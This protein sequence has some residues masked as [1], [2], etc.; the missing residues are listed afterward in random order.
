ME[1]LTQQEAA[2]ILRLSE[3]TLE[4]HRLSG[5]GPPF[6]KLGR[7]VVYRRADIEAWTRANNRLS[8]CETE[9]TT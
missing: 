2:E 1:F 6:V 4:R 8:T 9:A 5:D 7:R 3:R